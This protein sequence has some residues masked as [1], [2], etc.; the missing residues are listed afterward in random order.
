M[1]YIPYAASSKG[2]TGDI[3]IFEQ[4]E[5]G[6]LLSESHNGMKSSDKYDDDSIIVYY[7]NLITVQKAATNMMMIQ[8]FHH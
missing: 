2:K 8:I 6:N 7:R 5:E 4:F 3:I 1:S